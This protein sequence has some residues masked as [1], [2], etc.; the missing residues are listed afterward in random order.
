MAN[1]ILFRILTAINKKILTNNG[2]LAI[3]SGVFGNVICLKNMRFSLPG[4]QSKTLSLSLFVGEG[5]NFKIFEW[6][7]LPRTFS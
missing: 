6:P 5:T 7:H 2:Q 1:L 3:F 4:E